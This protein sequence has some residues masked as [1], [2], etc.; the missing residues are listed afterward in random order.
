MFPE[1]IKNKFVVYVV[2]LC[3][4]CTSIE[5]NVTVNFKGEEL[6]KLHLYLSNISCYDA[7]NRC[8]NIDY[9][10]YPL[11]LKNVIERGD[12]VIFKFN[13]IVEDSLNK[14]QMSNE[15]CNYIVAVGF[16]KD[17]DTIRFTESYIG[18]RWEYYTY[19]DLVKYPERYKW[20]AKNYIDSAKKY[21]V[22][23]Q[24]IYPCVIDKLKSGKYKL[25]PWLSKKI[26]DIYG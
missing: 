4:S 8:N 13:Y 1:I 12:T 20:V 5:N 25:D 24:Y 18:I 21:Q 14:L 3:W 11:V 26:K 2:I 15:N 23:Y 10:H 7:N 19:N 9:L 17:L 16:V 22:P 6:A